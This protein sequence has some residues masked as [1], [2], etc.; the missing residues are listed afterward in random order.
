MAE[1]L[2]V[3]ASKKIKFRVL[4]GGEPVSRAEIETMDLRPKAILKGGAADRL[5]TI[6]IVG[7]PE[8]GKPL[9]CLL[10]CDGALV[11]QRDFFVYALIDEEDQKDAVKWIIEPGQNVDGTTKFNI[12]LV[13]S[14]CAWRDPDHI[15]NKGSSA[16]QIPLTESFIPEF[17]FEIVPVS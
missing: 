17:R 3:L 16:K 14:P 2:Q 5:W 12:A 9:Y 8:A 15:P 11:G 4:V 6:E 10:R 1:E 13:D 7:E